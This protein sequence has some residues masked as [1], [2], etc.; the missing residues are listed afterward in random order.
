MRYPT[1]A[2]SSQV[3]ALA[4]ATEEMTPQRR[5]LTSREAMGRNMAAGSATLTATLPTWDDASADT[6]RL[7]RRRYLR[8]AAGGR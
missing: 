8:G 1:S 2:P 4:A 6:A 5:A 7:E 3:P